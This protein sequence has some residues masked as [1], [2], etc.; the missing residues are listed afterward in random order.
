MMLNTYASF[1]ARGPF[2]HWTFMHSKPF[3]LVSTHRKV[4]TVAVQRFMSLP[5]TK[6]KIDPTNAH[7]PLTRPMHTSLIRTS[8]QERVN[9]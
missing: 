4:K 9:I 1:Q 5:Q 6:Y 3:S 8:A 2:C 7:I